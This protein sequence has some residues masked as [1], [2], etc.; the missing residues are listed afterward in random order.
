MSNL[1]RRANTSS[2]AEISEGKRFQAAGSIIGGS[3]LRSIRTGKISAAAIVI[4]STWIAAAQQPKQAVPPAPV[5]A[6]ITAARKVFIAYAGQE[7]NS[8]L[9]DYN[10]GPDRTYNQFY[11]I[12][13]GWGRYQIVSSPADAD[14][15]LQ[16]AFIN[17]I[18]E[19]KVY[20]PGG[21]FS[22]QGSSVNDPQFRL[23]IL[24]PKSNVLLWAL[25]RHIHGA[26]TFADRENNFDEALD[27]IVNDL[28][29]LARPAEPASAEAARQ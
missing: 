19:V 13:K 1:T 18:A 5:P 28:K 25:S 29:R 20:G 23:L 26:K 11:A 22:T 27:D 3:M 14:M 16:I 24:D 6:Q 7:S 4:V 21:D 17:P 9:P 12:V 15:V 2:S 8:T 10:G